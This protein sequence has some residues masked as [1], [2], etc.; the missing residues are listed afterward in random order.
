M[1]IHIYGIKN[2]ST[3]KKAMTW[4]TE[5]GIHPEFHDYKKTGADPQRLAQWCKTL[6][7]RALINTRGTTW[8]TL[9]AT[10][11]QAADTAEGAIA[12]MVARPSLIRR[13]VLETPSGRLLVGFDPETYTQTLQP[14]GTITP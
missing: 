4:L 2:C 3:M 11:Q 6:G 14:S 9:S 1:T 10:E 5:H 8:R 7:W 13:P 12:L